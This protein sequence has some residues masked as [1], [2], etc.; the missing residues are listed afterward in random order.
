MPYFSSNCKW[1]MPFCSKNC[2]SPKKKTKMM[3]TSLITEISQKISNLPIWDLSKKVLWQD[4]RWQAGT[5]LRL[6]IRCQEIAGHQAL[7]STICQQTYMNKKIILL[8]GQRPKM[9]LAVLTAA[10]WQARKNH[11]P[12]LKN[13]SAS[14]ARETTTT[15]KP[16]T[17]SIRWRVPRIETY[18]H[19]L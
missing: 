17:W 18:R 2:F 10:I 16:R 5:N 13:I 14:K 1:A 3:Q 11:S 12:T 9:K 6:S 7:L 15:T 19:L 8:R 4:S